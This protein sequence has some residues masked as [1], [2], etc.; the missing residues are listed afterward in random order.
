M[1]TVSTRTHTESTRTRITRP[2]AVVLLAAAV[3]AVAV[4]AALVPD[5]LAGDPVAVD[6]D[7]VLSPPSWQHPFGTDLSGR[8]L[9]A[10]VVHGTR[11][12]L[13]IGLGATAVGLAIA[14]LLGFTSALAPKPVAA[15]VNRF[16]EVLFAFPTILLAL[17]LLSVFGQGRAMLIIAVG[18]GAAPGYARIIRGQVLTVRGSPY[19][20][21]AGALGHS[22][23]RVFRQHLVPNA[24]R[25]MVIIA[26]LGVGQTIVWASGLSFLGLGVPPPAPEWGALLN[27]G[28]T[29]ITHAWWLEV[30]PGLVIV[31][32]ALAATTLG[33][34]IERRLE[35]QS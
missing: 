22:R 8:D 9:Y 4:S 32:I 25:P 18:I 7:T 6:L 5:F 12:S 17:L 27:A 29:F 31:A 3:L 24:M 13:L 35:G 30:F 1:S 11:D 16:V 26:T 21:A 33:R 34:H 10:R 15:V 28:R 19:I 20:E 2:P 14:A 23:L